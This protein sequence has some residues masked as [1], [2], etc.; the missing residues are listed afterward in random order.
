MANRL[1]VWGPTVLLALG[2]TLTSVTKAQK[3]MELQARRHR[4]N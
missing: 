3:T 1:L 4:S 2:A